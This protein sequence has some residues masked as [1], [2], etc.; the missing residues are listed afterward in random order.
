VRVLW[1]TNDL[2]PRAGGIQQFVG[3]L[4]ARVH[5]ETTVVIG[6]GGEPGADEHDATQPFRTVRAPGRVL[7]TRSVR[8]LTV[9]TARAH[10]PDVLVL[11]ASW[12]LGELAPILAGDLGVPVLALSHGL[13]AGLPGVGLG[14]LVR[15]AT[16]GLA[17]LTTIS[18]WTEQRLAPHVRADRTVRLPPG[19]DV[20][21]FAADADGAAMRR[22]WGVPPDAAVVGCISRL[23]PRKGQDALLEVW[24][25]VRARHPDAW[26]VLVGEGPLGD[27]LARRAESLGPAA[28]VVLAGRAGW[29]ELPACYAALDLFA[30]PCRTRLAGL[31]VEGLGIV[32]LEAAA[33]RVPAIA[34]ASGGAPEAV[35]DGQT[36][37]VVDGRDHHALV[38]A[39]DRWLGDAEG[40]RR[41]GEAGR[42]WVEERWSW[43]VI[44]D[45]F[46]ALLDE[47]VRAGRET[48]AGSGPRA[49]PCPRGAATRAV[50]RRRRAWR[51][52]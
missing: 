32:Y 52:W 48:S 44:A 16:R 18:D 30:M 5:P 1:L 19:V 2:P 15:R 34:G 20:D 3:N 12:P 7:P 50:V 38:A 29:D 9:A 14:I 39:I 26:L 45:R 23:V 31:D 27:R 43:D 22:R 40:R 21:R 51:R 36:G 6:P 41:A 11:G 4:L 37:T 13:E 8:R 46:S 25:R 24:P 42:A 10:R 35:L 17:A 33:C 28:Q 47:V 49:V